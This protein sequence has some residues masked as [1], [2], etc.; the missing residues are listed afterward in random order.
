MNYEL[1]TR[2]D[3]KDT[4]IGIA[5]QDIASIFQRFYRSPQVNR[6]EGVGIGLFLARQIIAS[7]HGYIKVSSTLGKGS[8]F[9]IFLPKEN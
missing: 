2:I 8:T 5:E 6:Y 3:I 1:F 9:S 7:Q 4:G